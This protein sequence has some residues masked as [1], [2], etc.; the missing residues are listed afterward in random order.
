MQNP[1]YPV[2]QAPS[3][4]WRAAL[5]PLWGFTAVPAQRKLKEGSGLSPLLNVNIGPLVSGENSEKL[6][7]SHGYLHKLWKTGSS[8]HQTCY[9]LYIP[10]SAPNC[11]LFE[12]KLGLCLINSDIPEI[13]HNVYFLSCH[14][15][16]CRTVY[17]TFWYFW[18]SLMPV[19]NSG[20]CSLMTL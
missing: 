3:K 11:T 6:I 18:A 2:V 20:K 4:A 15:T 14:V 16:V 8:F 12:V 19:P 13:K 9:Y 7:G 17:L 10:G 1:T 5:Y